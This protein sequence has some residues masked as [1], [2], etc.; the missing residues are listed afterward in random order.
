VQLARERSCGGT[1]PRSASRTA[2]DSP[3]PRTHGLPEGL[4]VVASPEAVP[5][6]RSRSGGVRCCRSNERCGSPER[7]VTN[8]SGGHST[9]VPGDAPYPWEIWFAFRRKLAV[10]QA[11]TPVHLASEIRANT[12]FTQP[13]VWPTPAGRTGLDRMTNRRDNRQHVYAGARVAA[14]VGCDPVVIGPRTRQSV[15]LAA[16]T[17]YNRPD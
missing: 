9:C 5:S 2:S 14:K 8:A 6:A 7:N 11:E 10:P 13:E 16:R 3:S 17:R 12:K 4:A 15:R 1:L